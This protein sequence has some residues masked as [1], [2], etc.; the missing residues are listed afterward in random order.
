MRTNHP[1]AARNHPRA[2]RNHQPSPSRNSNPWSHPR[3][4][5]PPTIEVGTH[6]QSLTSSM[7]DRETKA[8]LNTIAD[9][10]T[11]DYL[12]RNPINAVVISPQVVDNGDVV[13]GLYEPK[14]KVLSVAQK[15]QF[16]QAWVPGKAWST[17]VTM[18][19]EALAREATMRHE[20]GHHVHLEKWLQPADRLIEDAFTRSQT[21]G[22]A[23]TEYA[24][25]KFADP[26]SLLG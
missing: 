22:V 24:R 18:P 23:I 4:H 11:R 3:L 20:L 10:P 15:Q 1:R 6:V 19:T 7:P 5:P 25:T 8:L 12:G 21:A 16:G 26:A 14:T 17:T 13:L 2:A 9:E